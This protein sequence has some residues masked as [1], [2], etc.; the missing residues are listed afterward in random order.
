MSQI[1]IKKHFDSFE[2]LWAF[3][4]QAWW[5]NGKIKIVPFP[6]AF[7]KPPEV[8]VTEEKQAPKSKLLV[9]DIETILEKVFICLIIT[10]AK[11]PENLQWFTGVRKTIYIPPP[12]QAQVKRLKEIGATQWFFN[13]SLQLDSTLASVV[14][15][16]HPALVWRFNFHIGEHLKKH[17]GEDYPARDETL[18]APQTDGSS[19]WKKPTFYE[20]KPASVILYMDPKI[21]KLYDLGD[22]VTIECALSFVEQAWGLPNDG[23]IIIPLPTTYAQIPAKMFRRMFHRFPITDEKKYA[24]ILYLKNIPTDS[25]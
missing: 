14:A 22:N 13:Y 19:W 12:L 23:S 1:K 25:D 3:L 10:L 24:D 7:K 5:F 18:D 15:Y 20:K 2:A 17:V 11:L 21:A 4:E 8:E 9:H 16:F 6:K